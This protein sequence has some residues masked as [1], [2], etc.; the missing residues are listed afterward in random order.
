VLD[1][2]SVNGSNVK[3]FQTLAGVTSGNTQGLST[4]YNNTF[5]VAG[6]V[7]LNSGD[8]ANLK[9]TYTAATRYYGG[10][11]TNGVYTGGEPLPQQTVNT[12]KLLQVLALA[13]V[14][15]LMR[16]VSGVVSIVSVTEMCRMW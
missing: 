5:G 13:V 12:F 7:R 16:L 11:V 15:H 6:L 2:F 8:A 3:A 1:G 4:S 10:T 9:A 14:M